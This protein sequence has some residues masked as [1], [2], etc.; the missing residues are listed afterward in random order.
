MLKFFRNLKLG[1]KIG[2]GY[3]LVGF[4]LV[5]AVFST[6]WQIERTEK[7]V[8]RLFDIR[9][10][11]VRSGLMLMNGIN[12]SL[13]ALRGWIILGDETFKKERAAAWSEGIEPS[14]H[15]LKTLSPKWTDKENIRRLKKIDAMISELKKRGQ[16]IEDIAQTTE[17]TPATKI[18]LEQGKPL[19]QI[20][21]IAISRMIDIEQTLEATAERKALLGTM[22][23]MRGTFSLA[24]AS[25]RTHL[26]SGDEKSK[27]QFEALWTQNS[28][29]LDDL[30]AYARLLTPEQ[31]NALKSLSEVREKIDK[32]SKKTFE[33]RGSD[34]WNLAHAWLAKKIVPTTN[35]IGE[36]LDAMLAS[37]KQ[38]VLEEQARL[39]QQ[40]ELLE[41]AEWFLLTVGLLLC[42]LGGIIITRGITRPLKE[43]VNVADHM[44]DRDITVHFDINTRD[45][46]G[47]LLSAMKKMVMNLRDIIRKVSDTTI[48]LSG[49]AEEL[50]SVA[51]Q[52]ASSAEEMSIQAD[53][54]A[55]ASEQI[56][57]SIGNVASAAEQSS[58]SV[59]SIA[60][61]TEEMSGTFAHTAGFANRTSENVKNMAQSSN[62]ISAGIQDTALAVEEMTASLNEVAKHTAQA[63]HISRNAS[64]RT[65]EINGK[66]KSLVK[67][68]KQVGKVVEMIKDIADQT[69]MLALNAAIEAASAGEAG[70]GFAVVAGEVRELARQSADATDEIAEQ[71]DQIQSR[72]RE[73]VQAIGE[74]SQ[75]IKEIAGI[76][77]SIAASSEEQTATANEISKSVAGNA[78]AIKN[79]A[80]KAGESSELVEEIARSTGE[81]S[82]TA[83][84]VAMHVDELAR[85]SREIAMSAGEATR[86]V[87]D[88]SR[89]IQGISMASKET[90]AGAAQ[91][92]ISSQRLTEMA[93]ALSQ[94]VKKFKL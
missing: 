17:N 43:A 67:V 11:T 5:G 51:T 73:V 31:Q 22:A 79:V 91:T 84:E 13:S 9:S 87:Q 37:Q 47:Q 72:T 61:M 58:S 36:H 59:S 77:E 54:V 56:T 34:E 39:K 20:T 65:D 64:R 12:H 94:I 23:D 6:L 92:N 76:N 7:I 75:I 46:T 15:M 21:D 35:S 4:V 52:M 93:S 14:L 62:E 71:I 60:A 90:A 85:G 49:S 19:V 57:A 24:D 1:W 53:S 74:I 80:E 68:S 33:I 40:T 45:E 18:V 8:N 82:K 44:A 70:K 38:L 78:S 32:L 55:S 41:R 30:K 28:R 10:P 81:A 2:L 3:G 42:T 83:R 25:I 66:M 29:H 16:E 27:K 48:N 50:S 26:I 63:S 89:N 69:N 86:G 88:V